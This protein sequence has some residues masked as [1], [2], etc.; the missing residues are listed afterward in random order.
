MRDDELPGAWSH[1]DFEGGDP[2]E[3]SYAERGWITP[4]GEAEAAGLKSPDEAYLNP[5]YPLPFKPLTP[6]ID[7]LD[8]AVGEMVTLSGVPRHLIAWRD[9]AA[10]TADAY[11]CA[12]DDL[13]DSIA[14]AAIPSL[15]TE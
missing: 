9:P 13:G 5:P 3:R 10:M 6:F 12:F 2:D 8:E 14:T 4:D 15:G 1:S 11:S 7:A